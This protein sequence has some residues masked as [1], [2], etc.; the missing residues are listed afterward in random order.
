MIDNISPVFIGWCGPL[1][2]IVPYA[3]IL[4][5]WLRRPVLFAFVVYIL[6][7][8]SGV[9]VDLT[10]DISNQGSAIV[11]ALYAPILVCILL[12]LFILFYRTILRKGLYKNA[13][14]RLNTIEK[15]LLALGG[16]LSG[17]LIG[18][19][20][21]L[22]VGAF[23]SFYSASII[24]L[25][26]VLWTGLTLTDERVDLIFNVGI[27]TIALIGVIL[28]MIIGALTAVN[29]ENSPNLPKE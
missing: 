15:Q 10:Q 3:I 29:D 18:G 23:I 5:R 14:D 20:M 24:G 12:S 9:I 8:V 22:V 13:P 11:A 6:S 2:V 4:R 28:G 27:Y 7:I 21:G 26:L 16:T 19:L 17:A 25:S 1:F